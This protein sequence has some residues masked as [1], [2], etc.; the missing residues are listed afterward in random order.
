MPFSSH[1]FSLSAG[2][3]VVVV[4]AMRHGGRTM[5][6]LFRFFEL[7]ACNVPQREAL[8]S[9]EAGPNF[10]VVIASSAARLCVYI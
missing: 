9:K 5:R 6:F 1:L 7:R 3:Y 2:D 8:S 10:D 4:D